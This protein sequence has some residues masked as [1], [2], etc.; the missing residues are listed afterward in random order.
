MWRWPLA[1]SSY[2]FTIYFRTVRPRIGMKWW[3]TIVVAKS[4]IV[5]SIDHLISDKILF[6]GG[7]RRLRLKHS[8]TLRRQACLCETICLLSPADCDGD[9]HERMQHWMVGDPMERPLSSWTSY[10]SLVT[11]CGVL[12]S[13]LSQE[14]IREPF[15]IRCSGEISEGLEPVTTSMW[16]PFLKPLTVRNR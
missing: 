9:L 12:Q 7:N 13:F 11:N 8:S 14:F 3:V 4:V 6:V 10:W 2:G 5:S 1:I 15:A 16:K